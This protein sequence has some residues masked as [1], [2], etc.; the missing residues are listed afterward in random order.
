MF[1]Y[2]YAKKEF[3]TLKTLAKQRG[4]SAAEYP[5]YENHISFFFERP[6]IEKLGLIFGPDHHTWHP[7]AHL[8]E[9]MVE[10]SNLGTFTYELVESPEKTLLY[11]DDSISESQYH[12]R[13]DEIVKRH[14]YEGDSV[15]DL[16]YAVKQNIGQTE[17]CFMELPSRPNF[18]QIKNKYAATVPHLMI[19]PATGEIKVTRTFRVNIPAHGGLKSSKW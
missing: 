2:H 1:L 4:G 14:K 10:L 19:Y 6:P 11:Y 17:K 16:L 3:Q 5:H 9:H 13:L 8:V 18:D 15:A 7:G 12:R